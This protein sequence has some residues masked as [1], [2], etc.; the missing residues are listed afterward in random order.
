MALAKG[1]NSFCWKYFSLG[2]MS[3][4]FP[5][6]F[7]NFKLPGFSL[8]PYLCVTVSEPCFMNAAYK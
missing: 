2:L 1:L 6:I 7:K 4:Q 3:K 5:L 8:T